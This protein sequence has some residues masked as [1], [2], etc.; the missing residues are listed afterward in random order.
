MVSSFFEQACELELRDDN[1]AKRLKRPKID[2]EEARTGLSAI[3]AGALMAAAEVWEDQQEG[4]LVLLLLLHGLRVSEAVNLRTTDLVL[5]GGHLKVMIT[6]K[7]MSGKTAVLIDD[8]ALR[9]RLEK[10][11]VSGQPIVFEE[12]DRFAAVRSVAAVGR[13]AE[14]DPVPHPHI[15]RHTFVAQA[16]RI[17]N[18]IEDVRRMA[19]HSS[20]RTTQRYA[21]AIESEDRTIG[22]DLRR[23]FEQAIHAT[24]SISQA[25][26]GTEK[27]S[28]VA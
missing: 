8:E 18:S 25:A 9:E 11:R 27:L 5:D 3:D 1:P 14:L 26:P 13:A 22:N 15:L 24:T 17:G 4:T 7:G 20:I 28:K 2:N 6:R 21:R 16:L 23:H 12:M 19:G 10:I